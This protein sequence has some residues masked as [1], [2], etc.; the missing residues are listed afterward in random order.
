[1]RKPSRRKQA[2]PDKDNP[3]WTAEMFRRAK[4]VREVMPDLV[5]SPPKRGRPKV[6]RPLTQISLRLDPDTLAAFKAQGSGWQKLM[7]RALD[8]ESTRLQEKR[9]PGRPA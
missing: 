1:M 4:P 9:K 7:R 6:E 3:E 5:A 8:R 2:R